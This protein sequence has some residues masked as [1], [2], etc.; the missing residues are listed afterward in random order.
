MTQKNFS[1]YADTYYAGN[2]E[3]QCHQGKNWE[4]KEL[5]CRSLSWNN[6]NDLESYNLGGKS[7]SATEEA[8]STPFR[9]PPLSIGSGGIIQS[10]ESYP[11]RNHFGFFDYPSSTLVDAEIPEPIP[12]APPYSF[13]DECIQAN[14]VGDN[15]HIFL[16]PSSTSRGEDCWSDACWSDDES[17]GSVRY[18]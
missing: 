3:Q 15:N 10:S 18:V 6:N 14:I 8:T 17:I 9:N 16:V 7:S 11:E 2:L 12:I 5:E 1:I 13:S 4:S